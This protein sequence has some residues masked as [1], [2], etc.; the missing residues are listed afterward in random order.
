MSF[1]PSFRPAMTALLALAVLTGCA[2]NKTHHDREAFAGDP[3]H[4]Q[5]FIV[6]ATPVCEAANRVLLGDGYV[7]TKDIKPESLSFIGSKEFRE[8]EENRAL[9][10]VYVTCISRDK[11]SS[12]FVTATE[13]RFDIKSAHKS[14][15]ISL[16]LVLPI[17]V[18]SSSETQGELK[19]QGETIDDKGFYQ[20]F[21]KAVRKELALPDN[22]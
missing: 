11:G 16:P 4:R 19:T 13:E 22:D 10:R 2:G 15:S 14:T 5:D 20:R 1:I 7:M 18:S 3:R 21:Y 8:D 6:P 12:L 9:L 17:S